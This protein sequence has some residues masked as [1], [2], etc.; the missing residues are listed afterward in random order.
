MVVLILYDFVLAVVI[1]SSIMNPKNR[2]GILP[3]K[4]GTFGGII[5]IYINDLL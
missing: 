2:S 3:E 5:Y 1:L 4:L